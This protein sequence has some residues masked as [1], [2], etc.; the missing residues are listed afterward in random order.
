MVR[1]QPAHR[2]DVLRDR[3]NVRDAAACA[4][5]GCL[6][7][8]T[9]VS[10][11]GIGKMGAALATAFVSAGWRTTVFNRTR[12]KLDTI[13]AAGAIA[14]ASV[15]D[16]VR[17]SRLV[18][19]CVHDDAAMHALL[20]P[21]AASLAGRTIVNLTTSLPEEARAN[22]K[23]VG[24]HGGEYLAG[25]IMAVPPQ[26]GRPEALIMYSGSRSGFAAF[27]A[28]QQLL[29]SGTFLGDDAGL[30]ATYDFALLAM[31]YGAYAGAMHGFAL[32]G[33]SGVMPSALLPFARAWLADVVVPGI[34][35]AANE[36]EAHDYSHTDSTIALNAAAVAKLV[37]ST[38]AAGMR[39]DLLV[40]IRT[41][42]DRRAADGHGDDS[43][44]SLVEVIRQGDER[45]A[46]VIGGSTGIGLATAKALVAAG[47]RV[48]V[49]G[50][51]ERNLE[52]AR[53]ELG[54][55]AIV[56]RVDTRVEAER[57]AL[58]DRV[59]AELGSIDLLFLNA[60]VAYDDRFG[61]V[62]EQTYDRTFDVNTKGVFFV[63]QRLSP[64]IRDG[65]AIVFTTS[66]ANDSGTPGMSV[67]AA[68]K[69]AIRAFVK[70]LAA[71]LLPRKIRVNAVSP[72]FIA[73]PTGGLTGASPEDVAAFAELGDQVT[74]MRRHG[75]AEEV[76]RA[77]LFLAFDAT[78]T[79]GEELLVDGGLGQN[80]AVPS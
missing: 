36:I 34:L 21:S 48:V 43:L 39:A 14:A 50:G 78:F 31:L 51:S 75:T 69:A 46:V 44:A 38:L 66:I 67:Y 32:A 77:V 68:S 28:G 61:T 56:M 41:L 73:T 1:W 29:G 24:E 25:T 60:G 59:T 7:T 10:L 15:E 62:T 70:N 8:T 6:M 74:P 58:H 11:I 80:L 22:A 54:P 42:L 52:S 27:E 17:A 9:S 5:Q 79:T 45:R 53:A 49:T 55:R 16:A 63:A 64:R 65:G 33:A 47:A 72:G 3:P 26:I 18:I 2:P 13:V 20:D 40:A 71:E 19:V 35:A 4:R 57:E 23:W 30:A 37:R 76:A 12:D